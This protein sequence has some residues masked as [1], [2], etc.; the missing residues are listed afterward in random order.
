MILKYI[1]EDIPNGF[2]WHKKSFEKTFE[3]YVNDIN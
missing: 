2:Q 1:G 3:E